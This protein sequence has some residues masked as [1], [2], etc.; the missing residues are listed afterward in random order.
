VTGDPLTAL[1]YLTRQAQ[2]ALRSPWFIVGFNVFTL[3]MMALGW[4][5]QWNY[6]A[7][8]LAIMVEWVVG[9]FM[10]GQTRRDAVVLRETRAVVEHIEDV[11]EQAEG[12]RA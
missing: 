6:I 12:E 9:T 7:S 3:T 5:E 4:R 10:F 1:E 2:L 8:W 11:M